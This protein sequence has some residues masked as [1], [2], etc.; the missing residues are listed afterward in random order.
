MKN[1]GPAFHA[2]P[3]ETET[4]GAFISTM[5]GQGAKGQQRL[6]FQ[7]PASMGK[8]NGRVGLVKQGENNAIS[9][10]VDR[11]LSSS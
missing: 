3:N 6:S 4:E 11:L 7:R 9:A 8:D 1:R 5:G 2:L 10:V